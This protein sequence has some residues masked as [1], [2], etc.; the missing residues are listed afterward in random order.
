MKEFTKADWKDIITG[1]IINSVVILAI[2]IV[3]VLIVLGW[4]G[5]FDEESL[6]RIE[7]INTMQQC[8]ID[9]KRV[10]NEKDPA[11]TSIAIAFF[12]H[13][14]DGIQYAEQPERHMNSLNDNK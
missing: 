13:R 6:G 9:A 12:E 1:G 2:G 7:Q 3:I 5:A 14:I 8:M 4:L 10:V 11:L